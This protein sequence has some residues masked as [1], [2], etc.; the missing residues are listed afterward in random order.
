MGDFPSRLVTERV[1]TVR[2]AWLCLTPAGETS[3]TPMR[4]PALLIVGMSEIPAP[5]AG[6]S[7]APPVG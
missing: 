1:K 7:W 5:P 4:S 2:V 3:A 6:S